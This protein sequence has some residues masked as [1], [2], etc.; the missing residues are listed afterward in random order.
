[1]WFE[2]TEVSGPRID[3]MGTDKITVFQLIQKQESPKG[4]RVSRRGPVTETGGR[5][6]YLEESDLID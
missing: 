3:G 5:L 2:R 6:I 1:M 4:H